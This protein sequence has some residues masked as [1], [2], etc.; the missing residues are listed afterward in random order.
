MGE[1]YK[2]TLLFDNRKENT[3]DKLPVDK[4]LA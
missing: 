2:P 4:C 3:A 1:N